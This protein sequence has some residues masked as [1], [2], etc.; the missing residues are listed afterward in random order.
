MRRMTGTSVCTKKRIV[1]LGLIAG[2]FCLMSSIQA[3][4][5]NIVFF[6]VDDLGARDLR[7]YGS[8]FYSTPSFDKLAR[9]GMRFNQAYAAHPRCVPSRYALMTG[10]YPA[11]AGVPG[12][13]YNIEP[14][15]PTMADALREN[16]YATFF[17]G[18]WHLAKS[19]EQMPEA[20]GFDVNVA[21]E[22]AGAPGTYW[23]PYN[24]ESS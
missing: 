14:D 22:A 2:A 10:R 19:P 24:K 6:L 12:R 18:K 20:K 15:R 11:R 7:C 21:G 16:G 4:Q 5:P 23:F 17:A 13:S 1:G 8:D 3:T 9:Q